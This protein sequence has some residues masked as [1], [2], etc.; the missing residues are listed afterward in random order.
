MVKRLR[1]VIPIAIMVVVFILLSQPLPAASGRRVAPVNIQP[2]INSGP[3]FSGGNYRLTIMPMQMVGS[4]VGG[5]YMLLGPQA[6][7]SSEN[8]CCCI[9]LPCVI[10]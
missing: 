9:Y 4:S 3:V 2:V 6:P 7:A 8:G 5:A 10:K 1:L